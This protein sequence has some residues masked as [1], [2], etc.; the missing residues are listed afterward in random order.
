MPV[1]LPAVSR[2]LTEHLDQWIGDDAVVLSYA[3]MPTELEV[4]LSP[5]RRTLLL[6]RTPEEG[7]LTIHRAGGP[8]ER[9]RFGFS[10]PVATAPTWD[11][12]IDAVLVPGL[13]FSPS[14]GRLGKGAGY[15]DRLLGSL[16]ATVRVGV[17]A[18]SL[19]VDGL[20]ADPHDVAM[21]HL[22]TE[23]GVFETS[24]ST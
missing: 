16:P 19:V 14:G 22:A 4:V 2:T 9:H 13:A 10:Q 24:V 15:Y 7:G 18:D 20:P 6:T 11:G 3:A 1:D 8:M 17:T 12:E 5:R 21:T 23:R